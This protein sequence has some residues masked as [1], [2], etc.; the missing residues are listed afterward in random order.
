MPVKFKRKVFTSGGSLRIN[1][2]KA[3][4]DT[5]EITEGSFVEMWLNNSH[6]VIRAYM[7]ETKKET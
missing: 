4:A 7:K 1:I 3:I 6:I 2:P 5:L